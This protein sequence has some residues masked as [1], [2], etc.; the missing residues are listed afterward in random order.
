MNRKIILLGVLSVLFICVTNGC[1]SNQKLEPEI[2][3][4]TIFTADMRPHLKEIHL[5]VNDP[6]YTCADKSDM[7]KIY[8]LLS[9]LTLT[10]AGSDVEAIDGGM[11]MEI[12]TDTTTL[13]IT[14]T[15]DRLSIHGKTYY[16]DKD[17]TENI[18]KIFEPYF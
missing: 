1:G 5:S 11:S 2:S 16:T 6:G 10:D 13:S 9:S 12:S 4:D 17:I 14:L 7:E 18:R 3:G 15:P 8:D